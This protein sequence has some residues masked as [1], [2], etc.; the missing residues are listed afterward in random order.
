M[1]RK[2]LKSH[3]FTRRALGARVLRRALVVAPAG[4]APGAEWFKAQ[5]ARTY[6]ITATAT[7]TTEAIGD[8]K[9]RGLDNFRGTVTWTHTYPRVS[10]VF[11]RTGLVGTRG[12]R[13][14]TRTMT[15]RYDHQ[16]DFCDHERGSSTGGSSLSF[17]ASRPIKETRS[18]FNMNTSH[19]GPTS[20]DTPTCPHRH[21]QIALGGRTFGS[22]VSGGF[23]ASAA[24][25]AFTGATSG[26]AAFPV[27]RLIAGKGFSYVNRGTTRNSEATRDELAVSGAAY[28]TDGSLKA[29]FTP[30]P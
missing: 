6:T 30:V 16:S 18:Y 19:G 4:G 9:G 14:T 13:R 21:E 2:R 29:V 25:L 8:V 26:R 22:T 12:H 17:G 7:L 10:I 28:V 11:F 1:E 23:T 27:D 3:R 5:P 24:T 15:T 20:G